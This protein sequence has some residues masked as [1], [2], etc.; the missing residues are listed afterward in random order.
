MKRRTPMSQ[1]ASSR[2]QRSSMEMVFQLATIPLFADLTT[3]QLVPVASVSRRASAAAGE[4]ICEQ[5][6]MGDQLYLILEGEVE[7]TRD[8]KR[9][10]VLRTGDCF[11]E[12]AILDDSPRS[13]TVRALDEVALIATARADFRDLLQLYPGLARGIIAVL[14]ERL[15]RTKP[16]W[17]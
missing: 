1:M 7:V 16:S 3:E 9:L 15:R 10:A 17:L 13:A 8:G 12:M 4:V 2:Y 14:V 11:G 5:G 6:D